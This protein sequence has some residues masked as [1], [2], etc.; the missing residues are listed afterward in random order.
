MRLKDDERRFRQA[1]LKEQ[2]TA[3][4]NLSLDQ[5]LTIA[6]RLKVPGGRAAGLIRNALL[7]IN[8]GKTLLPR[9]QMQATSFVAGKLYT[10]GFRGDQ[11]SPASPVSEPKPAEEKPADKPLPSTPNPKPQA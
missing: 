6:T 3:R 2:R 5:L 9:E 4:E 1:V 8:L 7:L 10:R 11:P